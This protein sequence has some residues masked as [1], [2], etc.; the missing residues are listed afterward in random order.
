MLLEA[1]AITK[2]FGETAVL[3]EVTF[4]AAEGEIVSLL[5]PS[6]SGK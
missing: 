5:G 3:R 2:S 4:G 1:R 6:G